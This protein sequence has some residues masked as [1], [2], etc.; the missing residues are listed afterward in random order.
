MIR[1]FEVQIEWANG[2]IQHWYYPHMVGPDWRQRSLTADEFLT[3][4][5]DSVSLRTT[6]C[7]D[8]LR[9]FLLEFFFTEEEELESGGHG[10]ILSVNELDANN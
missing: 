8:S 4:I 1:R 2:H 3:L 5:Q 6:E 10:T 9:E 7:A